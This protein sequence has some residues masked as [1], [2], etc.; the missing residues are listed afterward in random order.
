MNTNTSQTIT[1]NERATRTARRRQTGAITTF[2]GV[3]ILLLLTLMMFFAVRVGVFEQRVSSNEMRQKHAFHAAD[4]GLGQAREFFSKYSQLIASDIVDQL[5]NGTDGW[6]A[7]TSE[8][9]WQKC[10]LA[11]GLDLANGSGTHPCY[12]EGLTSEREEMYYYYF[13]NSTEVPLNTDAILPGSSESVS[14]QAL[15]CVAEMD[16]D[17]TT[18]FQRCSTNR[19][20]ADGSYYVLTLLARGGAD[21]NGGNCGAEALI[22]EK[23]ANTGAAA[24]GQGPAVP[25]TTRTNFPPSGT[26]EVVANPNAGGVGVPLTVWMNQNDSCDGSIVDPGSGA[27]A[28]CERHEWYGVDAM[29]NDLR[30]PS[31]SCACSESEAMSYTDGNV[32]ILGYDL[33]LDA[34]FPCDLFLFYF[35]IPRSEYEMIKSMATVI[36]D[37]SVLNENSFGIYW[38]TGSE[39]LVN[40]NTTIGSV[41]APVLLISAATLTRFNGNADIFGVLMLTDVESPANE[42]ESLG[43]MT[44]YGSAIIDGTIGKY[45]GTFRVVYHESI[46]KMPQGAGLLASIPGGWTD[47]HEN[48]K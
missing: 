40:A 15:L 33:K 4:A 43:T 29:P 6:M 9:R 44:T 10:S 32:N 3:L 21:C 14:V 36:T 46:T 31:G 45:Q 30:C 41:D 26:A 7:P 12:G 48:W 37:C 27:W 5:P 2:T 25:L 38:V 42:F 47:F 23:V 35:G 24:G 13:N 39:C 8:L 22:S 18:P 11:S 17:Q 19:D 28:T 34:D 16:F 20:V 1:A